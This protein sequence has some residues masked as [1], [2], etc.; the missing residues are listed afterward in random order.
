M[1]LKQVA[2]QEVYCCGDPGGRW[3]SLFSM[4]RTKDAGKACIRSSNYA[5]ILGSQPRGVLL[6]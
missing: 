4:K 1:L 2:S 6:W 3:V 5:I